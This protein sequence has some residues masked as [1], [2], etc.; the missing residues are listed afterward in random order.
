MKCC[1]NLF[2]ADKPSFHRFPQPFG[3]LANGNIETVDIGHFLGDF[4]RYARVGELFSCER[5]GLWKRKIMLYESLDTKK[6]LN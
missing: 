4:R 1:Q 2:G 5:A 3:F 6:L